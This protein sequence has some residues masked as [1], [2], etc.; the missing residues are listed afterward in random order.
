MYYPALLVA[1]AAGLGLWWA[2]GA[3]RAYRCQRRRERRAAERLSRHCA[4]PGFQ[5]PFYGAPR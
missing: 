1:V 4:K 5:G 2:T 3:I